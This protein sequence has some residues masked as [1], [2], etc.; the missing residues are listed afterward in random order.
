VPAPTALPPTALPAVARAWAEAQLGAGSRVVRV[1]RL[2]GAS[3]SVVHAVDV[4]DRAAQCHRLVLRR[5][6]GP[7]ALTEPDLAAREVLDRLRAKGYAD[8][9]Y[10]RFRFRDEK[11]VKWNCVFRYRDDKAVN[12]AER[13]FRV[14]VILGTL[15]NVRATLAGLVEAVADERR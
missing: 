2:R 14:Y 11:V 6:V 7:I 8:A 4:D 5:F 3:A 10:G 15:D 9:G 13:S 1:R 12:L